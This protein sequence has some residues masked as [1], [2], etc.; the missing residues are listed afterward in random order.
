M[1]LI[2]NKQFRAEEKFFHEIAK[3]I[4]AT[5]TLHNVGMPKWECYQLDSIDVHFQID[6]RIL[7][8]LDKEGNQIGTDM[9]CEFRQGYTTADELQR[10]RFNRFSHLLQ[11]VRTE[12]AQRKEK[13]EK[14]ERAT[15]QMQAKKAELDAKLA[16]KAEA[17]A[18]IA[19]ATKRLK[20]L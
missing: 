14:L 6:D 1:F 17:E 15:K 9:N 20:E 8:V 19:N 12:Y 2:F 4:K 10:V 5:K 16:Q 11:F 18:V 7:R 13:A 3:K